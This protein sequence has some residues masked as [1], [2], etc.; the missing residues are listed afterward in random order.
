MQKVVQNFTKQEDITDRLTVISPFCSVPNVPKAEFH[1]Y[2]Q[3]KTNTCPPLTYM[4][5]SGFLG[6]HLICIS[7][8]EATVCKFKINRGTDNY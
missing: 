2:S 3:I 1:K 4:Y 7:C 5:N 8:W 6:K